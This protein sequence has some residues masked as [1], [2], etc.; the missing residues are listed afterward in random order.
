MHGELHKHPAPS[1]AAP[2]DWALTRNTGVGLPRRSWRAAL[3][4]SGLPE[5]IQTLIRRVVRG[6][7]GTSRERRETADEL[8][9][10]FASA[11]DAGTSA[12]VA[13][14]AFG[15][16][17]MAAKLLRRAIR[18]KRGLLWHSWWWT[19]RAALAALACCIATY[20]WWAI[21]L[22]SAQPSISVDYIAILEAL[23]PPPRTG[24]SGWPLIRDAYAALATREKPL[25]DRYKSIDP[26]SGIVPLDCDDPRSPLW[27]ADEE[28]L[29]AAD[30][31]V[32]QLHAAS[33][34]SHVSPALNRFDEG[35]TKV[36]GYPIK[37][38][39]PRE[40]AFEIRL[41]HL[42]PTRA[43]VRWL[44]ADACHAQQRGDRDRALE[45]L[46][47]ILRIASRL[48]RDFLVEQLVA[49]AI[50]GRGLAVAAVLADREMLRGDD[51]PGRTEFLAGLAQALEDLKMADFEMTIAAEEIAF[52]DSLQ[53]FFTDDGQGDGHVTRDGLKA[54]ALLD[55]G[56]ALILAPAT[57]A[58]TPSRSALRARFEIQSL[59]AQRLA[60]LPPWRWAEEFGPRDL[61]EPAVGGFANLFSPWSG[62]FWMPNIDR[63][64]TALAALAAQHDRVRL[65]LALCRFRD[66]RGRWPETLDDLVPAY[67][68]SVPP[69]PFDGEPVRYALR[70]GIPTA[71]V[72]GIDGKDQRL[73][74]GSALADDESWAHRLQ[75]SLRFRWGTLDV[76]REANAAAR[77]V[78]SDDVQLWPLKR[79]GDRTDGDG[80]ESEPTQHR[81]M[82]R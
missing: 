64:G 50:A 62:G 51:A 48:R 80:V 47:A 6:A 18:R 61:D 8:I 15:N 66:E 82:S 77:S 28:A 25:L 39:G 69:D 75:A 29:A 22:Y 26:D 27:Q 30:D 71:W 68:S 45:S 44:A 74:P 21:Q 37:S 57:M 76:D 56:P 9:T 3:A 58:F 5:R 49:H 43:A 14:G 79:T 73:P 32:R 33:R 34:H 17:R 11:I 41:P 10:H 23:N 70:D 20:A 63:V 38:L 65:G 35:D 78:V 59:R 19:S 42:S 24:E 72:I 13:I 53:R 7:G 36:L 12:E 31:L 2:S 55:N 67:L 54:A 1:D 52:E 60:S 46:G 81:F 4:A 40:P 16:E